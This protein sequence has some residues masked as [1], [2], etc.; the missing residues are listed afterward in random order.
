MGSYIFVAVLIL[1]VWGHLNHDEQS[2]QSRTGVL[3]MT[4]TLLIMFNVQ[5]V[6]LLFPDERPVFLREHAGNMYSATIYFFAKLLSEIPL[7]LINGSL[8]SCIRK[9]FIL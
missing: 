1:L 4:S 7:L 2:I 6:I 8:Y 9:F 5:G 3:F